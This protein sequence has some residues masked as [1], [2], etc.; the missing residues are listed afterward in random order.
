MNQNSTPIESKQVAVAAQSLPADPFEMM[1]RMDDELIV[2]EIEGRVVDTWVYHFPGEAGVEQ[3][4]LSKV[5]VDASCAE[6]AKKGEVIRELELNFQ[7]DP[8][9]AE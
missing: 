2:A 6:L 4:G 7:A 8:V 3:W 9:D 1:D 5:G